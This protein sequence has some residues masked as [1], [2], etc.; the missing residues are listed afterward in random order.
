[1][2]LLSSPI[3]IVMLLVQRSDNNNIKILTFCLDRIII[4]MWLVVS[5]FKPLKFNFNHR[6]V[7]G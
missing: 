4:L 6:Y 5:N 1:M 2:N 7:T 3:R